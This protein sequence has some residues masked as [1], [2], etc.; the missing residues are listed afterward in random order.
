[1]KSPKETM[2]REIRTATRMLSLPQ[3]RKQS[4]EIM[5]HVLLMQ[6]YQQAGCIFCYMSTP[7]EVDT[8]CILRH[9]LRVGK[10]VCVPAMDE[11]RQ[12]ICAR[13]TDMDALK[14]AGA[15]FFLPPP[16]E[17]VDAMAVDFALIPG[18]AFDSDLYRLGRGQGHYDRF[19]EQAHRALRVAL[20]FDVQWVHFVPREAHD[21]RMHA[22]VLPSGVRR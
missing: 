19:L 2:R 22:V 5:Q 14:A 1:M 13:L 18:V 17:T 9:A 4:D 15:S 10:T 21:V 6:E 7:S 11:H 12:M 16:F 8:Q 3:K 20:A